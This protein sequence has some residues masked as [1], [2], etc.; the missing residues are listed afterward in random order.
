MDFLIDKKVKFAIVG[1][2]PI[3]LGRNTLVE[4][5]IGMATPNKYPPIFMLSDFRHLNST[6][7]SKIDAFNDFL[8]AN[9]NGYDNRIS[10]NNADEYPLAASRP[11][12]RTSTATASSTSTTCS[13]KHFDT[14]NDKAITAAEFTNPSTGKLYDATCS[15]RSTRSARRSSR[16]DADRASVTSD[17]MIDNRDGYTKVR[18]QISLAATA[19]RWAN[20]LARR[21]R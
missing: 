8:K 2:V 1:K 21:A 15:P 14:N 6:L 7:A 3:Q 11:A 13:S 9:H 12:T 17:G 19:R 20:N 10:V 5:P 16:G 4:G 18:G